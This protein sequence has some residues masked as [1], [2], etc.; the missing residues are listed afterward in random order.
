MNKAFVD[1][2]VSNMKLGNMVAKASPWMIE[3]YGDKQMNVR[4][5][6][7]H[8]KDDWLAIL[9]EKNNILLKFII[10]RTSARVE[11]YLANTTPFIRITSHKFTDHDKWEILLGELKRKLKRDK[12]EFLHHTDKVGNLYVLIKPQLK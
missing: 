11:F 3:G 12:A 2:M 6:G 4:Y 5:V 1:K 8:L 10:D 7:I 9:S